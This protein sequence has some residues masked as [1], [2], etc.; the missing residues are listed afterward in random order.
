MSFFLEILLA[1]LGV[2]VLAGLTV[3][4]ARLLPQ[5]GED[6]LAASQG[7]EDEQKRLAQRWRSLFRQARLAIKRGTY[8][9]AEELLYQ[10]SG[11][12]EEDPKILQELA[13]TLKEQG[14]LDK[15]R[16]V[17][18]KLAVIAPS[19][20]ALLLLAEVLREQALETADPHTEM[21]H[22]I[23]CY[24]V[25]LAKH[26]DSIAAYNGMAQAYLRIDKPEQAVE[27]MERSLQLQGAQ[28][29]IILTLAEVLAARPDGGEDLDALW[30]RSALLLPLDPEVVR[31]HALY[32]TGRGRHLPA[33]EAVA[34]LIERNPEGATPELARL[35]M[36]SAYEVNRY[37]DGERLFQRLADAEAVEAEDYYYLALCRLGLQ[38][39]AEARAAVQQAI[40]ADRDALRYHLAKAQIV[41][42]QDEPD[43]LRATYQ[44]ILELDP[45]NKTAQAYLAAADTKAEA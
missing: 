41:E 24:R 28:K 16:I 45:E 35:A 40:D 43:E 13:I 12:A 22:A 1:L 11:I 5:R 42:Q 27:A 20:R 23:E 9:S 21:E 14:K 6:L 25:I 19:E 26:A 15:A 36:R 18:E 4:A 10:A 3:F 32:L 31:G 37:E 38:H 2:A 17:L 44:R 7:L 8:Q 29:E 30:E 33:L 39:Y 34:A